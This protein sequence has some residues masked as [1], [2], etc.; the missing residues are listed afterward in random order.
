MLL[1]DLACRRRCN[2]P[3]KNRE[4]SA[5]WRVRR[6]TGGAKVCHFDTGAGRD[7]CR[8]PRMSGLC[9]SERSRWQVCGNKRV[10]AGRGWRRRPSLG[11][12]ARRE[13]S[14]SAVELEIMVVR[15]VPRS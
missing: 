5:V 1:P 9:E 7:H 4:I 10:G 13:K 12:R 6:G 15:R 3:A 14:T 8:A 11:C 2:F